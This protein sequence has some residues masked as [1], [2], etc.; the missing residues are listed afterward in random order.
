M[1]NIIS[2]SNSRYVDEHIEDY[3]ESPYEIFGSVLDA[4]GK[5]GY[6]EEVR[7]VIHEVEGCELVCDSNVT[8]FRSKFDGTPLGLT[9][10]S[11][12]SQV[13]LCIYY[14]IKNGYTEDRIINIVDCGKNAIEYILRH[15]SDSDLTLYLGHYDI[16][17]MECK[18]ML[19]GEV[20]NDMYD[21]INSVEGEW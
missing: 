16:G 10:L 8:Q 7:R 15:Y 9:Y 18:F 6:A 19:N 12:G 3:M 13:V 11:T 21:I 2:L 5:D 1:I 14:M 20:A 17:H 4:L